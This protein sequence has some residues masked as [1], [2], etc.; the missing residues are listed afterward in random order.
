MLLQFERHLVS[1][2]LLL[3]CCVCAVCEQKHSREI[4]PAGFWCSSVQSR[5]WEHS[6]EA[7]L[8]YWKKDISDRF[9]NVDIPQMCGIFVCNYKPGD[10][11]G[12]WAEILKLLSTVLARSRWWNWS[13]GLLLQSFLLHSDGLT[14]QHEVVIEFNI[15]ICRYWLQHFASA[16]LFYVTILTASL[17]HYYKFTFV[18]E[19][20]A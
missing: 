5:N 13:H 18:I 17:L 14:A 4:H 20:L 19:F 7:W 3:C 11:G 15:Y 10:T 16:I 8:V 9:W 12:V 1:Y 2:S 6:T